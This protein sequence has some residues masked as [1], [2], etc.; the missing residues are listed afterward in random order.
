VSVFIRKT[1]INHNISEYVSSIYK[2]ISNNLFW[3]PCDEL[4]QQESWP[5]PS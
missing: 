4:A 5:V 2:E 3:L 1:V